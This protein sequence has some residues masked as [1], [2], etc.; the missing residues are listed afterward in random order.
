MGASVWAPGAT[1]DV[2]TNTT[3]VVEEFTAIGGQTLFVLTQFEYA[4][5]TQS[6][7]VY[8]EGLLVSPSAVTEDSAGDRFSIS[9]CALGEKVTAVGLVGITGEVSVPGDG[10]I[11]NAKLASSLVV[12]VAKG[13]TGATDPAGAR[14]A[15][16]ITPANIGALSSSSIGVSVQ[17]YDPDTAKLDVKQSWNAQQTPMKG[18]LTDAGSID[19][20]C[21]VHGQIVKVTLGGNRSLNAPTNVVEGT[22]YM[23]RVTQDATGGR[24]LSYDAG[25]YK[26]GTFGAP[27]ITATANKVTWLCFVGGVGN[28][29]EYV[30]SRLDAV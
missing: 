3:R 30:G 27:T 6:L 13:G 18:T 26:F 12:P 19:W 21:D 17:A 5:G 15:L 14:T 24:T 4:P 25:A 16:E 28:T 10:T 9:S 1:P 8:R 22:C 2:N 7:E 11:T 29:M 20:D 23:V